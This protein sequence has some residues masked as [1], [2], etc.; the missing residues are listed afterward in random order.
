MNKVILIGTVERDAE[1]KYIP[2]GTAVCGFTLR[3][4][5][6]Y[7]NKA[8]EAKQ[9][10]HFQPVVVWGQKAEAICE[11]AKKGSLV[12]VQGRLQTKTWVDQ[13]QAKHSVTEVVAD[14]F[15]GVTVLNGS[16]QANAKAVSQ[17][18]LV[19]AAPAPGDDEV[20]F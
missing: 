18:A 1:L 10:K 20:P 19:E 4:E 15:D 16:G 6:N 14:L 7:T 17:R 13:Q 12:S 9:S 3:I 8:G 5:N 2:N 11:Q